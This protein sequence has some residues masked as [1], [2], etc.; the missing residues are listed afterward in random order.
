MPEPSD[1]IEFESILGDYPVHLEAFEGP[2]DLLL[3][4]IKRHQVNVYDIPIALITQQY[5]DYLDLM[6]ELN[7][8]VVGEFLVMAATLIHIKSRMLL[9]RPDPS[10]EDPEEDPRE[11]LVRRLLE[12]QRFKAAAELL[13]E[14]EIQRSAQWGRPDG[15]VAEVVGEA[16]EPELEVDLF[17]LMSAFRH[18]LE[19]VRQRPRVY[20]PPEQMSIETRIEQLLARLDGIE[21][22][23][24][25]DLFEDAQTR[26]AMVVTFLALLEMIR[27]KILRVF[28]QQDGAIR[29]YRRKTEEAGRV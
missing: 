27:M 11:A 13:H 26:S 21:A 3:H 6:S 29:V 7:L 10:Q 4:L 23:G 5:L 14:K 16:P 15:R 17:S 28:Q 12:H 22:C 19:R 25:E 1:P 8:D 24:F 18:V 20:L 2:L 9:P